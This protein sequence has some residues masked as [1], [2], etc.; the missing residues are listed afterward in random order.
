[1]TPQKVRAFNPTEVGVRQGLGQ[2]HT[3]CSFAAELTGQNSRAA[4]FSYTLGFPIFLPPGPAQL[5]CIP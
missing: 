5:H 3:A 1:M 2:G 4:C